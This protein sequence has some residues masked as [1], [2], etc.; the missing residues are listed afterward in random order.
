MSRA[1]RD[2][3]EFTTDVETRTGRVTVL[4]MEGGEDHRRAAQARNEQFNLSRMRQDQR[5][6]HLIF[7]SLRSMMVGVLLFICKAFTV[8]RVTR[9][10]CSHCR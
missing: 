9:I 2:G 7:S 10:C 6:V 3:M 5:C 4:G 8:A 1:I